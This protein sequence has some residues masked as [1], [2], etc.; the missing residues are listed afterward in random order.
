MIDW[1]ILSPCGLPAT[2][3]PAGIQ[4]SS[5][6]WNI[7][8]LLSLLVLLMLHKSNVTQGVI[9]VYVLLIITIVPICRYVQGN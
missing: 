1:Y 5:S 2:G 9:G 4:Q 3:I 7:V 8:M 6:I